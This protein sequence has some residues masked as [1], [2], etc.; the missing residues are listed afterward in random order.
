M[1]MLTRNMKKP[2]HPPRPSISKSSMGEYDDCQ[3]RW[4]YHYC[5]YEFDYWEFPDGLKRDC[6]FHSKLMGNEAFAGQV[7]HDV[8][9]ET[10]RARVDGRLPFDPYERA[11]EIAREY[12]ADSNLFLDA[13]MKGD[14][15]PKLHRQ[16]LQRHFFQEGFDG[17]AKADFR[18]SV[19]MALLNFFES[20]LY[21]EIV[22]IDPTYYEFPPKGGAP[23]FFSGQV[24]VYA[25]FDF[26]LRMPEKTVL[27][28]WKTGRMSPRAEHDVRVQLHTYAAYAIS[29]WGT[30]P[31]ELRLVAQWLT[32][33]KDVLS[34][35]TVDM[36]LLQAIQK[37]WRER[38]ALL[39]RR[40]DESKGSLEKL[41][42][43]FPTN[44]VEKKK[45]KS[46]SF[47]FCEGYGQYLAVVQPTKAET[48]DSP[49]DADEDPAT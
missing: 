46:C 26:A 11:K 32:P 38:H 13:Y 3:R 15:A 2:D 21:K 4:V 45:C 12:I 29:E 22:E 48:G 30:S 39:V 18:K 43:L 7:V 1:A 5:W 25:N 19:E 20:E 41:W 6:Q 24:P 14:K 16:P 17:S 37:E 47:R 49:S 42:S 28:D 23:W 36:R 33:G 34:E 44:G 10:L 40:R 8:I 31:E 27:Y 9:E 35:L